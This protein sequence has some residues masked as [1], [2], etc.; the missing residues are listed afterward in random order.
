MRWEAVISFCLILSAC[1]APS[2]EDS[3]VPLKKEHW[4]DPITSSS[5][6][7]LTIAQ[8]HS[9]MEGWNRLDTIASNKAP[10]RLEWMKGGSLIRESR[11]VV[12]VQ[13]SSADSTFSELLQHLNSLYGA[14]RPTE[15]YSTWKTSSSNGTLIE[16][17]LINGSKL[18]DQAQ[19]TARWKEIQDRKYED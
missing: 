3:T 1:S 7:G 17:E 4:Y 6:Y 16:V 15:G 10:L 9:G 14:S 12:D 2:S 8:P 5:T 13:T 18:Y 19:I 11:L